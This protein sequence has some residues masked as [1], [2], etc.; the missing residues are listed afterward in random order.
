M[1]LGDLAINAPKSYC[2]I[3]LADTIRILQEAGEL[4]LNKAAYKEDQ[5][6]LDYLSEL[7]NNILNCYATIIS[8]A[9]DAG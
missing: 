2:E 4:S 8:G 6:V 1:S 9:K 7:Q 3:Y 5:D